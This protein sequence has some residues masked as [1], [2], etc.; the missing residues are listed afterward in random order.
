MAFKRG[1]TLNWSDTVYCLMNKK[2]RD[3]GWVLGKWPPRDG[4]RQAGQKG[5]EGGEF[6]VCDWDG[7]NQRWHLAI[8]PSSVY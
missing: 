4:L 2:S 6:L 5:Q 8:S 1:S 7:D 3:T